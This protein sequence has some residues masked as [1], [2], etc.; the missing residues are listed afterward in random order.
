[1]ILH[2]ETLD[3]CQETRG[4]AVVI[5]VIRA[6]TTAAQIFE[7][8]AQ[9]II[10]VVELEE[11]FALQ[12][13]IPGAILIGE[14]KGL[15]VAGFDFSNSPAEIATQRMDSRPVIFR[16]SNGTRGVAYCRQAEVI[17][18]AGLSNATATARYIQ[19]LWQTGQAQSHEVT[20]VLTGLK[21]KNPSYEDAV[22]ADYIEA[23]LLGQTPDPAQAERGVRESYWGRVFADP[24]SE[25]PAEDMDYCAAVD[26]YPFA[27]RAYPSGEQIVLRRVV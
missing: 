7:N 14:E 10:L 24:D 15:P 11:A 4:I 6:F 27:M 25:F 8:G 5:D 17:L 16:S 21:F 19:H 1:M 3:T 26:R 9:E 22:A 2:R 18:G 12:Q 13:R 20:F 23:L